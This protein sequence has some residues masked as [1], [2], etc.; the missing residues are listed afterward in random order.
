MLRAGSDVIHVIEPEPENA[1]FL[2]QRFADEAQVTVHQYAVSHTD[3]QLQLHISIR[4]DGTPVTYGHT[5]LR[6]PGSDEIAWKGAVEVTARSLGSL[7]STGEI[8]A[9]VGVLKIDTEGHD[10]AVVSGMG[11]L[12]SDVVM[13]EHWTDLPYALGPCPWTV[14]NLLDALRPRGFSEYA[15]IV[16]RGVFVTLQ[17]KDGAIPSGYMGNLVFLHD[18]VVD[19]L[20]PATMELASSLTKIAVEAGEEFMKVANDRIAV[21][22]EVSRSRLGR[23]VLARTRG[24]QT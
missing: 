16:H 24:A 15:L 4:P 21:I 19:R 18:R 11:N 3:G 17:W 13:V 10:H 20:L 8:P 2:R 12:D 7:V 14:E 6:R 9:R 22:N 23:R 5:V 1:A